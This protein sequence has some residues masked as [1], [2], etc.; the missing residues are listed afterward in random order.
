MRGAI[1]PDDHK[2]ILGAY[3]Q[4]IAD[5]EKVAEIGLSIG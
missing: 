1:V 4:R 3:P 5:K 2:E